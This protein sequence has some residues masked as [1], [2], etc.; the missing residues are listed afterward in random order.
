M[1]EE[2]PL[3]ANYAIGLLLV[4]AMHL[5]F[6]SWAAEFVEGM[7]P[8]ELL[9]LRSSFYPLITLAIAEM[10]LTMLLYLGS[11]I[12]HKVSIVF[13]AFIIVLMLVN[14][15]SDNQFLEFDLNIQLILGVVVLALLLCPPVWL[16]YANSTFGRHP[17]MGLEE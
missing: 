12:A 15:N 7:D 14:M 5:F 16:Y 17:S 13:M 4:M 1:T 11:G 2:R 10:V 6:Y 9:Y 8:I 3:L